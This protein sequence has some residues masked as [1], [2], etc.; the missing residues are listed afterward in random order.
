MLYKLFPFN[1]NPVILHD[2][3]IINFQVYWKPTLRPNVVP[4]LFDGVPSYLSTPSSEARSSPSKRRRLV[5]QKQQLQQSEWLDTD[6]I[7][8][9]DAL[10]ASIVC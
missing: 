9:Y 2:I 8:L 4:R 7:P 1:M 3:I 5:N 6:H 10:L